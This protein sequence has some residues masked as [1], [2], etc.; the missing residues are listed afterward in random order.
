MATYKLRPLSAPVDEIEGYFDRLREILREI[1]E[2]AEARLLALYERGGPVVAQDATSRDVQKLISQMLNKR[3]GDLDD[4]AQSLATAVAE[5]TGKKNRAD[6]LAEL[7][8]GGFTVTFR[9]TQAERRLLRRIINQ[10]VTLIKSIPE[11]YLSD[12]ATSVEEAIDNGRDI[13][14]L[15]NTLVEKY[16]VNERRAMTIARTEVNKA[17]EALSM[18]RMQD[19]GI[20]HGIWIHRSASRYPRKTHREMNGKEFKLSEGLFD[21]DVG[22]NVVPGQLP[23]CRCTYRA[24]I[25]TDEITQDFRSVAFMFVMLK[26]MQFNHIRRL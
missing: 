2:E 24:I 1:S 8:R 15:K 4:L 12:V 7:K 26:G 5:E 19:I 21:P 3:A 13:N 11:K 16:G 20:T 18:R 6:L 17:Y 14:T 23:N 10:N 25:K 9:T 22:Y